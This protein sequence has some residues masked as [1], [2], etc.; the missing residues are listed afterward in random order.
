MVFLGH[1]WSCVPLFAGKIRSHLCS[2]CLLFHASAAWWTS[3][4]PKIHS[5][6]SFIHS[7]VECLRIILIGLWMVSIDGIEKQNEPEKRYWMKVLPYDKIELLWNTWKKKQTHIIGPLLFC[8][9]LTET[10]TKAKSGE[11]Q[12]H[13]NGKKYAQLYP[14]NSI[15]LSIDDNRDNS[16]TP[17]MCVTHFKQ[18]TYFGAAAAV[19]VA[20]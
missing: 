15:Y 11:N 18:S 2:V 3:Y 1:I 12:N 4:L 19:V 16:D 14:I 13:I 8:K 17:N 20:F 6:S 5:F 7:F 9:L 10:K